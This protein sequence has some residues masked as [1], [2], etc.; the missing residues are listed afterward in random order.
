MRIIRDREEAPEQERDYTKRG[1]MVAH[2]I[3][4]HFVDG[5]LSL[6]G[7]AGRRLRIGKPHPEIAVRRCIDRAL[8]AMGIADLRRETLRR[9]EIDDQAVIGEK[10]IDVADDRDRNAIEPDLDLFLIGV[11]HTVLAQF[12]ERAGDP[13]G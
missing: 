3:A 13:T 1:E 2:I 8:A 11:W 4:G 12:G 5:D 6:V 7:F 10:P 9:L